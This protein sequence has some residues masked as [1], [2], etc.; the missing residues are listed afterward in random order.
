MVRLQQGR[1]RGGGMGFSVLMSMGGVDGRMRAHVQQ[2]GGG[3]VDGGSGC[4]QLVDAGSEMR[5]EV[6][7]ETGFQSQPELTAV[8]G[9]SRLVARTVVQSNKEVIDQR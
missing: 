6:W 5:C 9:L 4:G 7:V 2:V 8:E 3:M 1:V